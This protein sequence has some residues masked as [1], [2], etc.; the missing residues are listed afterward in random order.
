MT[1]F[2]IDTIAA[3]PAIYFSQ[4]RL[5]TPTSS[6]LFSRYCVIEITRSFFSWFASIAGGKRPLAAIFHTQ[7]LAKVA[8]RRKN[9]SRPA[10]RDID[11]IRG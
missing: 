5:A 8:E 4:T 1:G 6:P 7:P 9:F 2:P 11:N 10:I 3:L